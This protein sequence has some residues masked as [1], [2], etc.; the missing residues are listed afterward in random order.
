MKGKP[1]EPTNQERADRIDSVMQAYCL[2]LEGCDWDGD[3]D[4]VR[5]LLADMM[6][7]CQRMEI[8]FEANLVVA[9]NNYEAEK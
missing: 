9:R 1:I 2:G 7:F 6:H 4:D 5:D 3:E 8:D